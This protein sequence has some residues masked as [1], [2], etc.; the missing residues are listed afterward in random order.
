MPHKTSSMVTRHISVSDRDNYRRILEDTT[1]EDRYCRFFHAVDHFDPEFID[2]YVCERPGT[3]GFIAV[4]GEPLG[5]AHAIAIDE[6][7]AELAVVVARKGRR[8]GIA[9]ALLERVVADARAHGYRT[10]IAYALR[11]NTA[12]AALAMHF[13]MRPDPHS[14]GSTIIWTLSL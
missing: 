5:T 8:R 13:G 4:N 9:R 7:T 14:D 1:E 12:F 6:R 11:E 10:L 3:I 2:Q